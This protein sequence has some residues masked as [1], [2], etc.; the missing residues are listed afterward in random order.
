MKIV[1]F[2]WRI[3]FLLIKVKIK[4]L[5]YLTQYLECIIITTIFLFILRLIK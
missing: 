5:S 3:V 1:L 2:Y 4:K